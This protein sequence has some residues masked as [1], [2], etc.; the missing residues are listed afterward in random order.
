VWENGGYFWMEI[1]VGLGHAEAL[2]NREEAQ[3]EKGC[4]VARLKP[5]VEKRR[6]ECG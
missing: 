3:R 6:A 4:N 1:M 2:S 5:N